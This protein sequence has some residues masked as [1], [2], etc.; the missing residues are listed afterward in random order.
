MTDQTNQD[1]QN[2]QERFY[3]EVRRLYKAV[4]SMALT[5]EERLQMGQIA[6]LGKIIVRSYNGLHAQAARLMPDDYFITE[7]LLLDIDQDADEE[8]QVVQ[9]SFA[10]RQLMMYLKD[11]LREEPP[12]LSTS[13]YVNS[14]DIEELKSLGRD[15]QEQIVTMTKRTLKRALSNIDFG[16]MGEEEGDT[17]GKRRVKV[18]LEFNGEPPVPPVPPTP[19]TPPAPPVVGSQRRV[20]IDLDEDD[21][22]DF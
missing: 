8:A 22:A 12:G 7:G 6:G 20:R 14:G 13:G 18:N 16:E 10:S 1:N 17:S 2:N 4:K 9:V 5:A 3:Q 11:I 15:L 21:S 19:P